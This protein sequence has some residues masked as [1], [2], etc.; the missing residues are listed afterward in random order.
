M[1][2]IYRSISCGALHWRQWVQISKVLFRNNLRAIISLNLFSSPPVQLCQKLSVI[3]LGRTGTLQ[4]LQ[5]EENITRTK[6]WK[7]KKTLINFCQDKLLKSLYIP[8]KIQ[9]MKLWP[10]TCYLFNLNKQAPPGHGSDWMPFY[11]FPACLPA[12][13]L[14]CLLFCF[15]ACSIVI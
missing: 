3:R 10:T 14:A 6:I 9:I 5:T 11:C 12:C 2:T 7:H 8:H 13:L 4:S 15:F 1:H